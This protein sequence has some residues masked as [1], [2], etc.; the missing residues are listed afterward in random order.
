[1]FP[2]EWRTVGKVDPATETGCNSTF[3]PMIVRGCSESLIGDGHS[4]AFDGRRR[5]ANTMTP[6]AFLLAEIAT[7]EAARDALPSH[8]HSAALFSLTLYRLE[9]E[10]AAM[11]RLALKKAA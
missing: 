11:R 2:G 6:L 3:E 1:V 9:E 4:D 5:K 10:A 8:S 7:L